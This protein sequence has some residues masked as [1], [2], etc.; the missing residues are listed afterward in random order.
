MRPSLADTCVQN[1]SLFARVGA[2]QQDTL[3][4][5][6]ILNRGGSGIG[7]TIARRQTRAIGAAF[8]NTALPLDHLFQRKTGLDRGQVTDDARRFLSPFQRLGG[9]GQRLRPCGRA[10]LAVFTYIRAIQTLTAQTIPDEP[11]LVADPFLVHAIMVTRQETHHFA[12]FGVHAD[13]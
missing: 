6:D 5:V 2:D 8:D 7:P 12:P 3:G 10:Q 11:G 4:A 13:V 9:F 1:R